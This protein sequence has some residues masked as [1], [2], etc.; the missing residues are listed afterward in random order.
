MEKGDYGN[1]EQFQVVLKMIIQILKDDNVKLETNKKIEDLIIKSSQT[2]RCATCP[3]TLSDFN[4]SPGI[5]KGK[6]RKEVHY[7]K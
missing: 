2:S 3:Y 6:N 1:Y 4:I 5:Q 7:Q